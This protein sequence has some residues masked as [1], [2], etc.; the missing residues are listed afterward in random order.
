MPFQAERPEDFTRELVLRL[1]EIA[2]RAAVGRMTSR[3]LQAATKVVLDSDSTARVNVPHYW[4]YYHHN[5]R[6]AIDL[7]GKG[8]V[9]VYFEDPRNDPRTG[10]TK[11]YPVRRSD[12]KS[13]RDFPGA[14]KRGLAENAAR[15]KAGILTPYMIVTKKVGPAMGTH[16]FSEGLARF[17]SE[18]SE[19]IQSEFHKHVVGMLPTENLTDAV[20]LKI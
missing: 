2:R 4:A 13:L 18:A 8:H 15:R 7:T 14:Y 3:T 12:V 20:R 19:L 6:R 11:N 17:P 16:F 1:G 9:M 10:G 5:G